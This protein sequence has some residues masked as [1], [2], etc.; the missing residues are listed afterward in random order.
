M[1]PTKNHCEHCGQELPEVFV[2]ADGRG[3][4]VTMGDQR[5]ALATVRAVAELLQVHYRTIQRWSKLGVF[6]QPFKFGRTV[7]Y[8]LEDIYRFIKENPIQ[9]G[10]MKI[11]D[12]EWKQLEKEAMVESG[13]GWENG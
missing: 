3:E 7:R 12:D 9:T 11:D 13:Q 6:P 1:P 4:L 5:L 2:D 10:N 8:N